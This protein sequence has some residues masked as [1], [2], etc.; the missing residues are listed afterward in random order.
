MTTAIG[1]PG[2]GA[3]VAANAALESL[4]R[5]R[6]A[7]GLP[8]LCVRWGA[9]DDA[10]ILARNPQ[11]RD[12]LLARIGGHALKARHA[13]D[14]LEQL[15]VADRSDLCVADLGWRTLRRYLPSAAEPK[16]AELA[17]QG[18]DGE[19]VDEQ[20]EDIARMLVELG[21]AELDTAFRNLLKREIGEI[22][23]IA[24]D[25]ID[26]EGSV[27]DMGLDS[28]MGVELAVAIES[29][30]GA[31]LPVM[32]LSD[33]PTVAKLA[34]RIIAQLQGTATG[35]DSSARAQL[36]AQVQS[37]LSQHAVQ[38]DTQAVERFTDDMHSVHAI[39]RRR[40]DRRKMIR[41]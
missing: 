10:G 13:L 20:S 6:R 28:M 21:P 17:L 37:A 11:L 29:R 4:A 2:Q 27:Y 31:R 26:D 40:A 41:G 16:F 9:I 7:A 19:A 25:R 36:E 14:I 1:N 8:A 22:L 12:A 38:V 24:P 35:H 23:R 30:F 33:S 15:M 18:A 3:Y 34:A 5:A 32:A 39:E